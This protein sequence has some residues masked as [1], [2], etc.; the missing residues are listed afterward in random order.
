MKQPFPA[1][2]RILTAVSTLTGDRDSLQAINTTKLPNNSLVMVENS[3]ALYQL[4][5]GSS[6]TEDSPNIVAP[7]EGGPG[8]W[9]RYGAGETFNTVTISYTTIP[10]QDGITVTGITV[11]GFVGSSDVVSF[12]LITSGIPSALVVGLPRN[13]GVEQ[14]EWRL[15]NVSGTTIAPSTLDL[16]VDVHDG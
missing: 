16:R 15:Y 3:N 12:D 14:A 1:D 2:L 7:A 11:P 9:Y 10:P 13:T 5:K 8:R 6:A 4:R